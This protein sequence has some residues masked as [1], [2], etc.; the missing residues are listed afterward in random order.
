MRARP[1][2]TVSSIRVLIATCRS[3]GAV[4]KL[5]D[6]VIAGPARDGVLEPGDALTHG[7]HRL[8]QAGLVE[9]WPRCQPIADR[10]SSPAT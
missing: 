2:A 9:L 7:V 8:G 5:V 3:G 10:G 4:L 1:R 6:A